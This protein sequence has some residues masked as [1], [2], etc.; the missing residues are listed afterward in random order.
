[1]AIEVKK[2]ARVTLLSFSRTDVFYDVMVSE[3]DVLDRDNAVG[4]DVF[5]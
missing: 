2:S 5:G 1:L 3:N 4:D